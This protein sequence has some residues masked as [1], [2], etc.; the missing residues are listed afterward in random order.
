MKR[1]IPFHKYH[2]LGN[3]FIII[4]GISSR[5]DPLDLVS[6]V[7]MLCSRRFG[8]GADGILLALESNE[9]D[10]QLRIFNADGSE[11]ENCGN[12]L[13]CFA[14]FV[15]DQNLVHKEIFSVETKAGIIIPALSIEDGQVQAVEV[16]MGEPILEPAQI[17]IKGFKTD[18]VI[19]E[20]L[21][22]NGQEY[23]I[24]SISMGNPHVIIFQD[25]IKQL[26]LDH[27]GPLFE[28]HIAFPKGVNVEFVE[29]IKENEAVIRVWERG[30]GETLACGTGACAVLVAGVLAGKLSRKST[31]LLP[32]GPL[33][34]E[35][36][37]SNNHI[38]MTGPAVSVFKGEVE[39]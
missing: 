39:I 37:K 19:N 38:M 21:K 34:I 36:N 5:I 14:H 31:L 24:S 30:V 16:D 10:I 23:T 6:K 28:N 18:K 1:H 7:S 29:I 17:P 2:G 8:V 20:I 33:S 26:Q 15:Y 25:N 4:D 32:G 22:V 11:P 35:W 13:R 9:A 27:I 12:G 3:D